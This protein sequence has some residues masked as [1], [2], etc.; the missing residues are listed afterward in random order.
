[1]AAVQ[2][3]LKEFFKAIQSNKDAEPSWK[4][5][6]YKIIARMDETLPDFF[7]SPNWIE[8]LGDQ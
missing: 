4:K 1:M 6:I 7:K 2:A 8:Q 3:A 5:A